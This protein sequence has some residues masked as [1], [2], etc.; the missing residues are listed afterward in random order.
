MPDEPLI[1][2]NVSAAPA[3]FRRGLR[4]AFPGQVE[5]TGLTCRIETPS[6]TMEI[7]LVEGAPRTI[8]QLRLPTL[9]VSIRFTAGIAEAQQEMLARMDRAMHRGGG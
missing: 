5:E 1:H 3:E 4:L 7:C 9:H 8:A 2:R 6:A